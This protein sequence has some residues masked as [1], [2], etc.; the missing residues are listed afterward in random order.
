KE[1]EHNLTNEID[2][3]ITE[4]S[5]ISNIEEKVKKLSIPIPSDGKFNSEVQTHATSRPTPKIR[6]AT[7]NLENYYVQL[8]SQPTYALAEDS[9]RN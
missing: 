5:S 9:L 8:A 7:Q 3:I 6:T 4:N 1:T 2:K